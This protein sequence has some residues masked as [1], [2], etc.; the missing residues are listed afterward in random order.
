MT[1]LLLGRFWC[2]FAMKGALG[3]SFDMT[4]PDAMLVL[5]IRKGSPASQKRI[6]VGR[7]EGGGAEDDVATFGLSYR[8]FTFVDAYGLSRLP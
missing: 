1:G 3:V 5:A 4:R 8:F 7:H 6:E 2:T